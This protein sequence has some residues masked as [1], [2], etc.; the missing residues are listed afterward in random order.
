MKSGGS[1]GLV[2]WRFHYVFKLVSG[3]SLPGKV[4]S[5][6]L[7]TEEPSSHWREPHFRQK[8]D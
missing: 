1:S 5:L 2:K 8:Y 6:L 3:E 4:L 7:I